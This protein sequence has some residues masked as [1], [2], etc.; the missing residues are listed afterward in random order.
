MVAEL[1]YYL[2]LSIFIFVVLFWVHLVKENSNK[3]TIIA[4]VIVN[5]VLYLFFIVICIIGGQISPSKI[6]YL[7]KVKKIKKIIKKKIKNKKNIKNKK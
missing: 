1:P 3:V 4:A 7:N 6:T 2:F 5:T